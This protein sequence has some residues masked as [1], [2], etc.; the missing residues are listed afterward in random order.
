MGYGREFKSYAN[1]DMPL[2]ADDGM[3]GWDS[4]FLMHLS[5]GVSFSTT[6]FNKSLF[7]VIPSESA[8]L[9]K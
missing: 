7:S 9:A 1:F 4:N 3:L 2:N 6:G 8:E 5:T